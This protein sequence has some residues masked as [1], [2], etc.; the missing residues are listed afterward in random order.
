[1]DSSAQP[2]IFSIDDGQS[3]SAQRSLLSPVAVRQ[4]VGSTRRAE[5]R[6]AGVSRAVSSRALTR[7][8]PS[9]GGGIRAA[10]PSAGFLP[11]Q[12][13]FTPSAVSGVVTGAG[14]SSGRVWATNVDPI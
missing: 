7:R 3:V 14:R 8:V 9:G 5:W 13:V 12:A 1:M 2:F 4:Q 6:S 10:A 11:R